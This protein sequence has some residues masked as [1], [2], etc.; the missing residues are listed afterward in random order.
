MRVMLTS[1]GL[2]TKQLEQAFLTMLGKA[3]KQARVLFV[4]TAAIDAGAVM[5]LGK[6]M[7]DMLKV[8]IPENQITVF[9]LHCTMAM[10]ELSQYDVVYLCGGRTQYLLDRMNDT[11]FNHVLMQYI[12]DGGMVIGVS[13]GSLI[14]TNNLAGNLGLLDTTLSVHSSHG[15]APGKLTSPLAPEIRLSNTGA[16]LVRDIPDNCELVDE[17]TKN[18]T[19]KKEI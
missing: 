16:I 17:A 1:C 15:A 9:D 13:A 6:C 10:A 2:E 18:S 19:P 14:F 7:N 5:V 3:P 4:P 8:G 11:G 12:A